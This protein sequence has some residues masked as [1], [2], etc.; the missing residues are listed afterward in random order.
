MAEAQVETKEKAVSEKRDKYIV[1][2]IDFGTTYSGYA[3]SLKH[4]FKNDPTKNIV[5]NVWGASQLM[6]HK[7]PTCVL[8]DENGKFH[9]FGYEAEENYGE[10]ALEEDEGLGKW[11]FFQRFKMKLHEQK[12]LFFV[13]DI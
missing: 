13:G 6:S 1:A 11:Y 10:L 12:V 2:A 5:T 9:S 8:F 3:F 7:A 4:D